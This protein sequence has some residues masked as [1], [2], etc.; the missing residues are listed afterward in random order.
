[1]T[2]EEVDLLFYVIG[3]ELLSGHYPNTITEDTSIV[4]NIFDQ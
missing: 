1:M 4:V 3:S 2:S